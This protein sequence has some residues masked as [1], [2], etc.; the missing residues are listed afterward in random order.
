MKKLIKMCLLLFVVM[1]LALQPADAQNPIIKN[2][3]AFKAGETLKCNLYFNWK[4]VWVRAGD[5]SLI[6]RDTLFNGQKAMAMSLLSSTNSRADKFFKMRDTLTTVFT[7]DMRPIYYRKASF[8][9]KRYYLNQAWYDYSNPDSIKVSQTYRRDQNPVEKRTDNSA[10]PV[11]DMMSLLA[12]ARTIDFSSMKVGQR[13]S[14]PVATG[15]RIE[16]QYLIYRGKTVMESDKDI[17][18]NC[19][20][21]SLVE[22]DKKGR[23]Q[24]IINFYVTDDKNKLPILL[25][26]ALNFGSAKAKLSS[27]QGLLYPVVPTGGK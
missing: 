16:T 5:A 24:T 19:I 26:L 7:H 27:Y 10:I 4:F 20:T 13:L 25:D 22:Y 18:Y 2:V 9:G 17:K 15:R 3:P 14:F 11:Y 8:E 23:E 1:F 12:Y 6:I 21:V